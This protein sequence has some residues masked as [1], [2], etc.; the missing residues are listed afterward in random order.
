M[1]IKHS[2]I[3]IT[4]YCRMKKILI[5][6]LLLLLVNITVFSQIKRPV[7]WKVSLTPNAVAGKE[8]T[9]KFEAMIDEGW[10]LYATDFNPDLGPSLP[11][12]ILADGSAHKLKGNLISVKSTHQFDKIWGG[13]VAFFV[14]KGTFTQQI[15]LNAKVIEGTIKG[16]VCEENGQCTQT[17]AKFKIDMTKPGAYVIE[18]K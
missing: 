4:R 3:F 1:F 6:A 18:I 10:H 5:P 13:E 7:K 9:L 8:A 11:E 2:Y 14:K 15:I 17:K 16:Q 12:L